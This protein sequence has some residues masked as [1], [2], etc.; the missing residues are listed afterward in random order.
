[1]DNEYLNKLK[2]IENLANNQSKEKLIK[3]KDEINLALYNIKDKLEFQKIFKNISSII[4]II[5]SIAIEI[6]KTNL[7]YE[8][9]LKRDEQ[10]IRILY[11][12]LL[13]QKLLKES[14]ENKLRLSNKKE[15]EYELIKEKTGAYIKNGKIIYNKQKENEIIILR[16]ENSNLKDMIKNYEKLIKEKDILYDNLNYEYNKD[17]KDSSKIIKKKK[18]YIPNISF[19]LNN[20]NNLVNIDNI[21]TCRINK[22]KTKKL[23]KNFNK[24]N[25]TNFNYLKYK[26]FSKINNIPLNNCL[27]SRNN[28]QISADNIN[29]KDIYLKRLHNSKNKEKK[30]LYINSDSQNDISTLLKKPLQGKEALNL[31][32]QKFNLLEAYNTGSSNNMNK[33][34]VSKRLSN[35]FKKEISASFYSKNNKSLLNNNSK[36]NKSNS[37]NRGI[38][39]NSF[40]TETIQKSYISS[41]PFN[42]YKKNKEISKEINKTKKEDENEKNRNEYCCGKNYYKK[43]SNI[44]TKKIFLQ[45]SIIKKGKFL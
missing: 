19:N 6:N 39:K 11:K 15:K 17:K 9:F 45:N 13:T 20:S 40:E 33:F 41:I 30:E 2:V 8:S 7:I 35:Y 32:K 4:S 10:T 43:Y 36:K 16:Q 25:Y 5:L 44:D 24:N 29:Q 14:L 21:Y 23:L 18:I 12:N 1:M 31:K 3:L 38:N 34:N 26:N 28:M 27:T 22:D 42:K 37:N